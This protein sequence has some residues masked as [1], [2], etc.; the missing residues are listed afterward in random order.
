MNSRIAVFEISEC[1]W[2]AAIG[3]ELAHIDNAVG[4]VVFDSV[5][6]EADGDFETG[7]AD[8]L[9]LFFGGGEILY[10]LMFAEA[11]DRV[12][13]HVH[14]P[15]DAALSEMCTEIV[16]V[17]AD[18]LDK[19]EQVSV[20]DADLFAAEFFCIIENAADA[21]FVGLDNA[22]AVVDVFNE[23]VIEF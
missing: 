4:L 18:A 13:I 10:V 7:A 9:L 3:E 16:C 12:V 1:H 14:F 17:C 11:V 20:S 19:S 21:V 6:V 8:Y 5:A 2:D 15:E 23:T 22:V